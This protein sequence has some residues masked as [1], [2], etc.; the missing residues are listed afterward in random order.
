MIMTRRR[1]IAPRTSLPA[2]GLVIALAL[3][4]C[5]A[6]K[7]E[8]LQTS[9]VDA[10]LA[11]S[12]RT[13]GLEHFEFGDRSSSAWISDSFD[14]SKS[15]YFVEETLH[16]EVKQSADE[17]GLDVGVSQIDFELAPVRTAKSALHVCSSYAADLSGSGRWWAGPKISVNWQGEE[18]AKQNGD[19]W[20]ENYI[21]EVASS[22]PD[23]LHDLFTGDYFQAEELAP[24]ELAGSTYRNYKIRFHDWWQFWSVRQDYRQRKN[25]DWRQH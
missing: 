5:A 3:T 19:D 1:K 16:F 23:Q 10:N 4:G 8:V 6:Q 22:T 20:Y 15:R 21:V 12:D 25:D 7:D 18:S 13:S 9:S 11:T 2:I 17:G 14:G 24:L